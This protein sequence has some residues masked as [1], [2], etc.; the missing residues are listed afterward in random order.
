MIALLLFALATELWYPKPAADWTAALPVGNGRLGAMVFG[1]I[2]EERIQFNESTAWTGQP[3]DYAHAGAYK[4]LGTIRKLLTEG[5]QAEA[6]ELAMREFMSVPLRQ[7]AYQ[8]FG[9]IILRFPH[10][11]AS[12]Y[13]RSLDLDSATAVVEYTA[14]DVRYRRE[15]IASYP[16]QVIAIRLTA[17]KPGSISF[18][19]TLTSPHA[20]AKTTAEPGVVTL[21]GKPADSAIQFEAR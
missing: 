21:S 20:G 15:V 14:G 18:D 4:H 19:A 6:E 2:G 9:D 16:G 13:R 3:R 7:K 5:R 8:P 17:S 12:S 11:S 1:G 10:D